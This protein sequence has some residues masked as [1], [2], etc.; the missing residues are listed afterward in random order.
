M[1]LGILS[2]LA[3][4]QPNLSP[5]DGG[6]TGGCFNQVPQNQGA[7]LGAALV[8]LVFLLVGCPGP[9]TVKL[10]PIPR[11][12]GVVAHVDGEVERSALALNGGALQLTFVKAG[13][14]E[15]IPA[16]SISLIGPTLGAGSTRLGTGI[17]FSP[18]IPGSYQVR[19]SA[20]GYK[21]LVEGNMMLEPKQTLERKL[22]LVPEGG[23]V[24]GRVLT[25]GSPVW[26][27][28]V[29]L[30]DA[31]T[32][33]GQDGT[34]SLSGAGGGAGTLK[35]RKGGFQG[36]D[37]SVTVSGATAAGDLSLTAKSGKRRVQLVNSAQLFTGGPYVADALNSLMT[38]TAIT[39]S[40]PGDVDVRLFASPKALPSAQEVAEL[41][42]FVAGG[43]TL[44]VTGEWGGFGDYDPEAVNART[45]PFGLAVRPDLVRISGKQTASEWVSA[46]VNAAFPASRDVSGLALYTGSSIMASP[47]AAM[48]ASTGAAGY[49]VQAVST[50]EQTMAA[51][52]P[53]GEGLVIVVGDTSAWV[54]SRLDE[55]GN[56]QFMLNL[57]GW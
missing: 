49:R 54:G 22:E 19:V 47:M 13:T 20:P 45:R 9:T 29:L 14:E 31:W 56:R 30:G 33:T 5:L 28:R 53:H 12:P 34:F 36:L 38:A 15:R 51:A 17:A 1:T 48:I 16:T 37:Q 27:A 6:T 4:A 46:A 55:V 8:G 7:R 3:Q 11:P 40:G 23:T 42:S 44:V 43:G 52:V 57:F 24:S 32:F 41:A 26:G 18:L 50:G 21:T 2:P 25:G 39:T 35:V 10:G